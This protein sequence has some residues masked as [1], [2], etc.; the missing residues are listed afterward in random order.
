MR[1]LSTVWPFCWENG[2]IDKG[3]QARRKG[4][5]ATAFLNLWKDESKYEKEYH[6]IDIK[7]SLALVNDQVK[8]WCWKIHVHCIA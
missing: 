7:M 1:F 2:K 6:L 3:P 4:H 8:V 5:F